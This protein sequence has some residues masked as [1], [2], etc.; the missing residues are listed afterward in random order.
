MK[1][2]ILVTNDLPAAGK[3]TLSE[4]LVHTLSS[5]EYQTAH[6][7]THSSDD[8]D[9]RLSS[10]AEA[11]LWDFAEDTNL[12]TPISLLDNHDVVIIDVG[13]GDIADFHDYSERTQL[14]D[15]L[16]ELGVEL[17]IALPFDGSADQH[18]SLIEIAE[19]FSDNAD[20]LL[21]NHGETE[22]EE[23]DGSYAQKVMSYLGVVE[24]T[25]PTP[26]DALVNGLEEADVPL[27]HAL[28]DHSNLPKNI[29]AA[30][31]KWEKEFTAIIKN[32]ARG[33]IFPEG[34]GSRVLGL[35]EQPK[36]AK[37]TKTATKSTS[38][39]V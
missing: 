7:A 33:V 22:K 13:T 32:E 18:E 36:A 39:S 12:A 15:Y 8:A 26:K 11:I 17:T 9:D 31:S 6:V 25:A 3:T 16:G 21:V 28:A 34:E 10:S 37:K 24:I 38:V 23:W 19:S 35:T 14:C 2:L 20:Y 27:H 4:I 5:E 29:R 1:K 30:L